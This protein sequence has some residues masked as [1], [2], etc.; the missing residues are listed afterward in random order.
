MFLCFVVNIEIESLNQ[1]II[2]IT[3]NNLLNS[4]TDAYNLF[5]I[6][7]LWEKVYEFLMRCHKC[8]SSNV[9]EG[10][11]LKTVDDQTIL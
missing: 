3:F 7:E 5:I 8:S 4:H 6:D 9:L 2:L 1:L 11:L 10:T